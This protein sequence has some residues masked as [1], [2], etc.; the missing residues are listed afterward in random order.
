M[1]LIKM[2]RQ[3]YTLST[4]SPSIRTVF[5][6]TK[7]SC[8]C[9][10]GPAGSKLISYVVLVVL[11][12]TGDE[13]TE[14][15]NTGTGP[16]QNTERYALLCRSC[17]LFT[18]LTSGY[19]CTYVRPYLLGDDRLILTN[20]TYFTSASGKK[21]KASTLPPCQ[22]KGRYPIPSFDLLTPAAVTDSHL[23]PPRRIALWGSS[24]ITTE[25]NGCHRRGLCPEPDIQ[26]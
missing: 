21:S 1:R 17:S 12:S 25:D 3:N 20:L 4:K 26:A 15:T 16:A 19:H 13:N 24:F 11:F 14:M 7:W 18:V 23:V 9:E 5:P 2:F 6:G 22:E 10:N 8:E